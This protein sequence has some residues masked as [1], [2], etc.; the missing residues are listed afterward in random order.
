MDESSRSGGPQHGRNRCMRHDLSEG[1]GRDG[2]LRSRCLPD[3]DARERASQLRRRPGTDRL[4]VF[5]NGPFPVKHDFE[6]TIVPTRFF[7]SRGPKPGTGCISP[8]VVHD[9]PEAIP[10]PV[11]GCSI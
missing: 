9:L 1:R 4:W 3:P 10:A 11:Q 6:Q 2:P 8:G 7:R 5:R